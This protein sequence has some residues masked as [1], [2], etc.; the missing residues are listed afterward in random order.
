M[1]AGLLDF[2]IGGGQ[3]SMPPHMTPQGLAGAKLSPADGTFVNPITNFVTRRRAHG[4]GPPGN[5]KR[6]RCNILV[7]TF[8]ILFRRLWFPVTS[9]VAAES[10]E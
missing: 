6:Q 1:P 9:S 7:H 2:L 10:L 4:D 8:L 3:R 5:L